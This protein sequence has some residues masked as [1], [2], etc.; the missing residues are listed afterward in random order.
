[1]RKNVNFSAENW[2]KSPMI[3]IIT[4]T[5]DPVSQATSPADFI[6][7]S[8]KD[9]KL[10]AK[11]YCFQQHR[12]TSRSGRQHFKRSTWPITLKCSVRS[13]VARFFVIQYTEMGKL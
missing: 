6:A 9:S 3:V 8:F 11:G 7:P 1:M 4:S 10:A 13:L 12:K 5:P 2:Q